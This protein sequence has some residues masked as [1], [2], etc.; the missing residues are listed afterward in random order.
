MVAI[1]LTKN[2][3]NQKITINTANMASAEAL[4]GEK[5]GAVVHLFNAVSTTSL[6]VTS[7]NTA[8]P[9]IETPAQIAA[10]QN[11]A[12]RGQVGELWA[13]MAE[14]SASRFRYPLGLPR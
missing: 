2:W 7:A 4:P 6:G 9:V 1:T 14:A 8:I 12:E 5:F 3:D 11:E 10:M 13:R